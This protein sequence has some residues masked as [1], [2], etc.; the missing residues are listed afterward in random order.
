M[1]FHHKVQPH[2]H[3]SI[4]ATAALLVITSLAFYT[5]SVGAE[6][7]TGTSCTTSAT[8][9]PEASSGTQFIPPSECTSP[10]IQAENMRAKDISLRDS[11]LKQISQ[12]QAELSTK[13]EDQRTEVQQHIADWQKQADAL[14]KQI[15]NPV[16]SSG[17]ATSACRKAVIAQQ[18]ERLETIHTKIEQNMLPALAKVDAIVNKV[19]SK[20]P[21]LQEAGVDQTKLDQITADITAISNDSTTL[22]NYFQT[23]RTTI[24]TFNAQTSDDSKAFSTM[25]EQYLAAQKA[26]IDATT[27]DLKSHLADLQTVLKS[28]QN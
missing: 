8:H 2:H 19:Q 15:D 23:I 4:W 25:K 17:S 11:L 16:T 5:N 28:L 14:K 24:D 20:L 3:V 9:K 22:K 6:E 12:A 7:C 10:A 21:S 18:K 27:A 26:D 1:A 13:P